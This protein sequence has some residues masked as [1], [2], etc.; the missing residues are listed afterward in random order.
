MT[1]SNP[2]SLFISSSSASS[3]TSSQTY[4]ASPNEFTDQLLRLSVAQ[5]CRKAEVQIVEH[6][7]FEVLVNLLK[8]YIESI[9]YDIK[10]FSEG[11]RK[12]RSDLKD[13][14][15]VIENQRKIKLVPDLKR[16]CDD[17]FNDSDVIL[18]VPDYPLP[19][20]VI[21]RSTITKTPISSNANYSSSSSS[22]QNSLRDI[23]KF[24]PGSLPSLPPD[25]TFKQTP[26]DPITMTS[27]EKREGELKRRRM[28]QDSLANI[29]HNS[30]PTSSTSTDATNV[31]STTTD[32]YSM[33]Q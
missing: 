5:I 17:A 7:V 4:S 22:S 19:K 28:I 15:H 24:F 13:V 30:F 18:P 1:S 25:H 20:R 26:L 10:V 16:I 31:Q 11:M 2:S 32:T 12:K 21:R 29:D 3:S 8:S 23:A 6:E 33:E 14:L 27:K 9:G